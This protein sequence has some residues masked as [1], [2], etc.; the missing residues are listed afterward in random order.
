MGEPA[1][2]S[3]SLRVAGTA[4][5]QCRAAARS[6]GRAELES[7]RREAERSHRRRKERVM[8]PRWQLWAGLL[9]LAVG[10]RV[11]VAQELL[12]Q[13]RPGEVLIGPLSFSQTVQGVP[14]TT[15]VAVFVA[16]KSSPDQ[17]KVEARVIADLA[18]LQQKI[19][20]LIDT[21]ALPTDNCNHFG[22]DNLV[23]RIWGKQI[24]WSGG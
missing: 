13:P 11:A 21:I 23:A 10:A 17:L 16:V 8:K 4:A 24:A 12:L 5:G 22:A 15:R 19:G 7:D 3:G 14:L 2:S 9:V 6:S 20:A 18:D 1:T